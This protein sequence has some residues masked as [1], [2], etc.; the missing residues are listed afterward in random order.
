MARTQAQEQEDREDGSLKTA[1]E[2]Q[3]RAT[4]EVAQLPAEA[5]GHGPQV[6]R[7]EDR[8]PPGEDLEVH[9]AGWEEKGGCRAPVV[10]PDDSPD[11]MPSASFSLSHSYT[12][13]SCPDLLV[14]AL[15][16]VNQTHSGHRTKIDVRP[17]PYKKRNIRM[18]YLI[19]R[20]Q[21]YE[22]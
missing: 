17:K 20:I 22:I 9:A 3:Q 16:E 8:A 5:V 6:E 11:L 15:V 13:R 10:S 19:S 2:P 14:P 21:Y 1:P 7:P 12:R 18:G 4:S